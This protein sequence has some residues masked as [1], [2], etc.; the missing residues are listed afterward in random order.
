MNKLDPY[1]KKIVQYKYRDNNL[2]FRV[3][4]SLFSSYAIDTGTQR[5]LRTLASEKFDA[6]S[7]V[8]DLGCGYGPIGIA[9]KSAYKPSIVHMVDRDALAIEYSRQ[10]AE[11]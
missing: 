9:L 1:F 7:K 10:N 8:L 5:L 3:S 6:Y 2:E 11:L 4:Q